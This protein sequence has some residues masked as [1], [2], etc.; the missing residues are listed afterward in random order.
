MCVC[1]M[2]EDAIR[3]PGYASCCWLLDRRIHCPVVNPHLDT[4]CGDVELGWTIV[5][6]NGM[7]VNGFAVWNDQETTIVIIWLLLWQCCL[8]H[9]ECSC[10]QISPV[11]SS[12][13][14]SSSSS[15]WTPLINPSI[16]IKIATLKKAKK[17]GDVLLASDMLYNTGWIFRDILFEI[18]SEWDC[19]KLYN[20]LKDFA[21]HRFKNNL[22]FF[23]WKFM[24]MRSYICY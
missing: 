2:C 3:G 11:F 15:A 13:L 16:R 5:V 9:R 1:N 21:G 17:S 24:S 8:Y 10:R 12:V 23:F 7:V 18:W 6:V 14:L 4:R 22:L 20:L 19:S